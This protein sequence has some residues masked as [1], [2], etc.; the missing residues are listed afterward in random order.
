[1]KRTDR[2][3]GVD[4]ALRAV[5]KGG[6]MQSAEQRINDTPH[7]NIN[8]EKKSADPAAVSGW[9]SL[10]IETD[11]SAEGQ[12][13][14]PAE[15]DIKVS[16]IVPIY[17]A[18]AFLRPAMD[19]IL[20]QKL[21]EIEVICVDD[22]STDGSLKIIKEYQKQ[23]S[24]I[25]IAT[26]SNA[27]PGMARNNGLRRARGEYVIFLDADDFIKLEFLSEMYETAKVD[28]LDIALCDY[29]LYH[30]DTAK[31]RKNVTGEEQ[32]LLAPGKVTSKNDFPD[33]IFQMTDGYV[34]SKLFRRS[35]LLEKKLTFPEDLRMFEDVY[36]VMTALSL[37]ERIGKSEGVWIH[38]RVYSD[39]ARGRLFRKYYAQAPHMYA[40]I[41]TFL[42]QHG[43]YLPLSVSYVNL[44]A[45]RCFKIYNL[46]WED[47]KREFYTMLHDGL[48]EQMGWSE[49]AAEDYTD[50]AVCRFAATVQMYSYDQSNRREARGRK[51]SFASLKQ[52]ME[53]KRKNRRREPGYLASLIGNIFKRKKK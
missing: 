34:W 1:M 12:P 24:R 32:G 11:R 52:W 16:V 20:D 25:R 18:E 45:S 40:N 14:N 5:G 47:A 10:A 30:N 41:K 50:P 27:G 17:N 35:F 4:L 22:G 21:R 2:G 31:F 53:R 33:Q 6:C 43:M 42:M 38:H 26:Q 28:D 9:Q 13:Q 48:A 7:T 23:D 36:F 51:L 8:N 39:Q 15:A 46:L 29:D 19:S 44:T 37:A 3:T 49:I